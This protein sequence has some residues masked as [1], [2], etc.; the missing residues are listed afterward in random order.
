M[1]SPHNFLQEAP[2]QKSHYHMIM[3]NNS[4]R[5]PRKRVPEV[6]CTSTQPTCTFHRHII[7]AQKKRKFPEASFAIYW[8][9]VKQS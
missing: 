3:F 2:S 8:H 6:N 7:A 1:G 9:F 4:P 5:N